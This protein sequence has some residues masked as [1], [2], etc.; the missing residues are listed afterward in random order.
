MPVPRLA[1]HRSA[2]FAR[3]LPHLVFLVAAGGTLVRL[4]EL[5]H[6]LCWRV[7][8]PTAAMAVLYAAGL[9]RWDRLGRARTLLLGVLLLLWTSVVLSLT[10]ALASGYAWL[11]VP[12]AVLTM[13]MPTRAERAVTLGV[14]TALLPALLVRA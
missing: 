3:C 4:V 14:I 10:G 2:G 1:V 13:R 7:A 9:A 11:A 6:E 12:F 8:P 5:N